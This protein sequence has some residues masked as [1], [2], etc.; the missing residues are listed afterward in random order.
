MIRKGVTTTAVMALALGLI[1]P[2]LAQDQPSPPSWDTLV[3][4]A[5]MTDSDKELECYRAAM[6]AAGYR[7]NPEVVEAQ[8]KK[9][10]GL[11]LPGAG[12]GK[13]EKTPKVHENAKAA[14]PAGAPS[15]G[16]E[17][18]N[19]DRIVVEIV[20]V[21]YTRP[22]NQL[23]IV[24]KDGGVWKQIDTIPLNFTPRAGQSMEVRKTAFGGYFCRFDRT[25]AVRCERRN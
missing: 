22:L 24:T 11:N 16:Q 12:G 18:E 17:A 4:C 1:A 8:K 7:R 14:P 6:K 5:N 2:A 10:F 9:T 25:N 21:A 19:A 13:P 3:R 23:L 15:A 20:E